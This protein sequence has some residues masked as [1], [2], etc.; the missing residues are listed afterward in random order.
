[1]EF[2]S[3]VVLGLS[4]KHP[5]KS[6]RPTPKVLKYT[7]KVLKMTLLRRICYV[8]AT[9]VLRPYKALLRHFSAFYVVYHVA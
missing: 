4:Y 8:G 3:Y 2:A 7:P 5:E 9:L 1:M 6:Y